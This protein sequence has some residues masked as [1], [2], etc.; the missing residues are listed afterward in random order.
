MAGTDPRNIIVPSILD[1]LGKEASSASS[2]HGI[3]LR[4]LMAAVQRDLEW[5]LNT[6]KLFDP[7]DGDRLEEGRKSI[8]AFGL[9][10]LCS[11]SR[12]NPTDVRALCAL[13]KETI[14]IFEPR[15]IPR[16]VEVEHLKNDEVDDLRLHF[17]IRGTLHVD[18]VIEPVS[19]DTVMDMGSGFVEI[20]DKD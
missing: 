19:F 14:R 16:T 1:R 10:D 20:E 13:I 6:R 7:E 4:E 8:L 17:R 11:Y 3:G 2:T 12:N 9:P 18:P 15:L 5:I